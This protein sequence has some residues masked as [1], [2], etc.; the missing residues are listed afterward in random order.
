MSKL[1]DYFTITGTVGVKYRRDWRDP[2]VAH[3]ILL[4]GPTGSGK[5]SFIEALSNTKSLG[6][7]KDQLEGFT[8]AVTAYKVENL[9]VDYLGK[10]YPVCLLDSPGFSDA[11]IS[12]FEVIE[13]V[14]KWLSD[15]GLRYVN[16]ILY[17]YPITDIRIPGSRRRTMEMLKSLIKREDRNEG[18]LTI[19]TTMWDKVWNEHVRKRAEANFVDIRDNLFKEMVRSGTGVVQ[20]WNTQESALEIMSCSYK[21]YTKAVSSALHDISIDTPLLRRTPYG[22]HLYSDLI[23]RIEGAWLHKIS[24][25]FELAHTITTSTQ[26]PELIAIYQSRLRET[27]RILHKFGAQLENFG[28]PPTGMPVIQGQLAFQYLDLLRQET[29]VAPSMPTEQMSRP[30]FAHTR[31]AFKKIKSV[32]SKR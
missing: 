9:L 32:L 27:V 24:L 20:F 5:S 10:R 1:C 22:A 8:Q 30:M 17:F 21:H 16:T 29:E 28:A 23:G 12:E 25:E 2:R 31:Q 18:T 15:Q 7:S 13:Q 3:I 19:V 11:N 14:R 26:D 6:I 4:A